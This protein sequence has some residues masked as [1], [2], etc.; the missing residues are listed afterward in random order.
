V[1][2]CCELP[3]NKIHLKMKHRRVKQVLS[4]GWYQWEGGVEKRVKEEEYGG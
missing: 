3:L 2:Y 1:K 4:E